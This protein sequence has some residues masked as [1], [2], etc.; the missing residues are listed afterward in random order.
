VS[1][2]VLAADPQPINVVGDYNQTAG[3]TLQLNI[4]GRAAGQFD[5]LNVTGNAALNGA[6]R[7]LNL[8]YQPE[9]RQ[10]K[11]CHDRWGGDRPV[12]P[13]A[14]SVRPGGRI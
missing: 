12:L 7:L 4:A 11:N 6:L 14:K 13:I 8:G 1:G 10:I 5:V 2:G 3:G 9:W